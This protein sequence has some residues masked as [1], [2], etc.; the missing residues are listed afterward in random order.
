[1]RVRMPYSEEGL[2]D[3][4][5]QGYFDRYGLPMMVSEAATSGAISRRLRWLEQSVASLSR[6]RTSGVPMF[7]Y[8]WWP[9]FALVTWAWC[10]GKRYVAYHLLQMGLW[11][12]DARL[13]R[14][15][16]P[17]VDAYRALISSG[18]GRV[19]RLARADHS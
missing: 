18:S 17:V 12:L 15:R 8:T 10:Q 7:G 3:R 1:L 11:D 6:L 2:I 9:M 14:I 19:G 13:E 16:A 4:I 5:A